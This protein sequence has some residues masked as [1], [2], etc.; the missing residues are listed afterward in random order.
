M[1]HDHTLKKEG[2]LRNAVL[3]S[4]SAEE[5]RH[6]KRHLELVQLKKGSVL[7]QAGD[8][9][10]WVH[11]PTTALISLL[12]S[13]SS[14]LS[15]EVGMV[16][17]EGCVGLPVLFGKAIH[18]HQGVV[19]LHGEALRASVDVLT[20]EKFPGLNQAVLRYTYLRVMQ[21]AQSAIC[22]RFH[23][24]KERFCRWLLTARDR[25]QS[26]ELQFTQEFLSWMIGAR[27]PVVATLANNLQKKGLIR[28]HRG[29]I[30]I[31]N[32]R[33]LEQ[34]TCECYELMRK[35]LEAFL[36]Y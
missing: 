5:Y 20:S 21:L 19:Q 24:V 22:L 8:R 25:A 1:S 6:V 30:T 33:G 23:S 35:E 12:G 10:Y 29:E 14:G 26:D 13:T 34:A 2:R 28:Y 32:R 17:W 4:L 36:G 11:F 31:R 9:I 27:R 18:Q 16:G 15:V 3:A 7:H